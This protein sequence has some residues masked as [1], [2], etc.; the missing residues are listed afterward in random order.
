VPVVFAFVN[1]TDDLAPANGPDANESNDTNL[2][3]NKE[4][5]T[6]NETTNQM[7]GFTSIMV[8][9]GLLSL[10]MIRRSQRSFLKF[11]FANISEDFF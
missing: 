4:K 11:Y 5:F 8:V 3:D 1:I 10:L 2:S 7:P 6:G 9:L